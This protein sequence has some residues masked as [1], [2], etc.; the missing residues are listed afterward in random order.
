VK[1]LA[2]VTDSYGKNQ[3]LNPDHVRMVHE[4]PNGAEI[5]FSDGTTLI[6]KENVNQVVAEIQTHS[7]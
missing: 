2:R 6:V 3:F 4:Y 5:V 1:S 7:S